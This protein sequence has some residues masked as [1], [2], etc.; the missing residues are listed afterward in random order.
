MIN[1]FV[2]MFCIY[3]GTPLWVVSYP[4]KEDNIVL[5][6]GFLSALDTFAQQ[7][8]ETKITNISTQDS[9]WSFSRLHNQQ[10]FYLIFQYPILENEILKK[11]QEKLA[12]NLITLIK[13]EFESLYPKVFF[14]NFDKEVTQFNDFTSIIQKRI[15]QNYITLNRSIFRDNI[16]LAKFKDAEKL[17]TAILLN[18]PI[19]LVFDLEEEI[20][21]IFENSISKKFI[22]TIEGL[23]YGMLLNCKELTEFK[24]FN[25]ADNFFPFIRELY[26]LAEEKYSK[27]NKSEFPKKSCIIKLRKEMIIYGPSVIPFAESLVQELR[28][29]TSERL[30]SI[31]N[32]LF[33]VKDKVDY[34]SNLF[35]KGLLK[36]ENLKNILINLDFE[37]RET[38]IISLEEQ[39]PELNQIL[40]ELCNK[41]HWDITRFIMVDEKGYSPYTKILCPRCNKE[42]SL[43][44]DLDFSNNDNSALEVLINLKTPKS[45][46]HEFNVYIDKDR[47]VIGYG[48]IKNV[49]QNKDI[50]DV[51]FKL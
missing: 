17:F 21:N 37:I 23:F 43:K 28:E 47:K 41:E 4:K 15:K 11:E 13:S 16:W 20:E 34:I 10:N 46:G 30:I 26:I 31:I 50:K 45:C 5:I 6:S 25:Q 3:N 12:Q 42:M 27:M 29:M 9:N 39:I 33:T 8:N 7:V 1:S 32:R 18:Y 51:M 40:M 48:N 44:L 35:Q 24:E 2:R 36:E 38:V 22:A 49:N 14:Q 19:F